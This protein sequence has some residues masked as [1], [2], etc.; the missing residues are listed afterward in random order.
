[1]VPVTSVHCVGRAAASRLLSVA[2]LLLLVW[3]VA[4][5]VAE[6]RALTAREEC[7]RS[8][9]AWLYTGCERSSGGGGGGGG[10]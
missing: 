4:G 6:G 3:A 2:A 10:M 9:G 1:V 8:G 7:A 5:C